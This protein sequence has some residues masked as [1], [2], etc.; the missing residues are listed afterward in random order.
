MLKKILRLLKWGLGFAGV[1]GTGY[2]LAKKYKSPA[3]KIRV[4]MN[5]LSGRGEAKEAVSELREAFA[6]Y[7]PDVKLEILFSRS[8]GDMLVLARK[9]VEEKCELV[10]VAGGDGTIN[11][12]VQGFAGSDV[13]LGIIPLGTG[14]V[15]AQEMNIPHN[16]NGAVEVI[17]SGSVRR[18]DL[19]K[20]GGHYF[21][22]LAGI[23]ADALVAEELTPEMKDSLGVLSY[24]AFAL[25]HLGKIPY[26]DATIFVDG[27]E[28]KSRALC[29]IAGNATSYDGKLQIKSTESM[30][31]GYLDVCVA[32]KVTP[33][34]IIRQILFFMAGRREYYRDIEYFGVKYFKAKRV[35]VETSPSVFVHTDGEAAGRTP[36]EC[37]IEPKM[38]SLVLPQNEA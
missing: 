16:I 9:S 35:R 23:G 34:G 28:I 26:F 18:V 17:A 22:W 20:T 12:A 10:C 30:D 36:C 31:D 13:P 2:Y 5:P 21:L 3:K 25:K 6:K 33:L 14:N 32:E 4:L 15:F 7:L 24:V 8:R 19:G 29:V 37:V 38:L 11:D 1:A 27:K